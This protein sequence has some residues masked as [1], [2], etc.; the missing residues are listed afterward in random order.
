[1]GGFGALNL[2]LTHPELVCA[3]GLLSPGVSKTPS[4]QSSA[5]DD[6]GQFA[7]DGRFSQALWDAQSYPALLAGYKEKKQVVPMY[8]ESGD[9]DSQVTPIMAAS[10]YM[11]LYAVEPEKVEL[12]IVDGAHDWLT[13]RDALPNA[14]RFINQQ[15]RFC[16]GF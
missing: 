7:Q 16:W 14:L 12:R 1:M 8:I 6:S 10:L 2:A 13:F 3:A 11:A 9:H 4:A 5:R 15:C